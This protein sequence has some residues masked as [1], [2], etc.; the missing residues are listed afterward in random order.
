[1]HIHTFFA[2]NQ[3][4]AVYFLFILDYGYTVEPKA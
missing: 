2:N 4:F 1:M 3:Y